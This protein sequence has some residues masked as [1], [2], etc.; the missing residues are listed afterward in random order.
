MTSNPRVPSLLDR[1]RGRTRP[2]DRFDEIIV[3]RNPPALPGQV[4][5]RPR[6]LLISSDRALATTILNLGEACDWPVRIVLDPTSWAP[7]DDWSPSITLLDE[8][9]TDLEPLIERLHK[10][11]GHLAIVTLTSD[12]AV[13]TSAHGSL[14]DGVIHLPIE[15]EE[16]RQRILGLQ[17]HRPSPPMPQMRGRLIVVCGSSG[18]VGTSTVAAN[19]AAALGWTGARS[20]GT[21]CA[22]VDGSLHFAD[23]RILLDILP[24]SPGIVEV[25]AATDPGATFEA[26]RSTLVR[27]E[28]GLMVLPGPTTIEA[29]ERI[30]GARFGEIIRAL[31]TLYPFTVVDVGRELTEASFL[32]FDLADEIVLVTRA[33]I[34]P[35]KN[36]R[37]MLDLLLQMGHPSGQVRLVLNR[38]G[39]RSG[40]SLAETSGIFDRPFAIQLPDD[41][42]TANYALTHGRPFTFDRRE[43]PLAHAV[44][45]LAALFAEETDHH[46]LDFLKARGFPKG[47]TD[48]LL[49][50]DSHDQM[51]QSV[52]TTSSSPAPDPLPP[53]PAPLFTGHDGGGKTA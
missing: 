30:S 25:A 37:L 34:M 42:S 23:Q 21:M 9:G 5:D 22:L 19:L 2:A 29:G 15:P 24:R 32:A 31:R 12:V 1:L 14:I 45:N 6:I 20:T 26:L 16:F 44:V 53:D 8:R 51:A 47:L 41:V 46:Q 10:T 28:P 43:T 13:L 17:V 3:E 39:A 7:A 18:G 27:L 48:L 49:S 52:V 38:V 36:A 35:L 50:P 40:L 33:E 11:D 4:L